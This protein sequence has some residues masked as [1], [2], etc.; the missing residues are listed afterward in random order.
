MQ[1]IQLRR[2]SAR[3]IIATHYNVPLSRVDAKTEADEIANMKRKHE[4]GSLDS[5]DEYLYSALS[6]HGYL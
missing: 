6:I 4:R 3:Q 5:H 2:R 1:K